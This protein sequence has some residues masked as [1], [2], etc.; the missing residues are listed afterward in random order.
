MEKNQPKKPAGQKKPSPTPSSNRPK[1]SVPRTSGR[2]AAKKVGK[3][4]AAVS[5]TLSKYLGKIVTYGLN[6][7]LTLLLIG[8]I[9]GSAMACAMVVYIKN[10]VDPV[11]DIENLMGD[12][13][14]T[15]FVYYEDKQADGTS[16][17]VEW[18]EERIH[19]T[20][21][22]MWVSYE[23]MP[24]DLINAFV[25]IEDKR[26]FTHKGV[27]I[28]R[29]TGAVLKFASGNHS[30][31]GSTITQ[32]LIKN[33]TGDD[34]VDIK[35]KIQE[36][37][38]ALNLESKRSKE[39]ILEMYLNTIYLSKG[40]YGVSAAAYEYFGKEVSE[41][42]LVECASLA[43]IP[44]N[45]TR[46]DPI[47]NPKENEKRRNTV[48]NEMYYNT[49]IAKTYTIDEIRS[50]K[51]ENL[52]LVRGTEEQTTSTVHSWFVDTLIF[53]II[54][55]L[56][57]TYNYDE[58]TA[59]QLLYSGGLQIYS[60]IDRNMQA[61]VDAIYQNDA[62]FPSHGTGVQVESAMTI[63]EQSTGN[64]VAIIG[65]R[66]VKDTP[67]GFNRATMAK[68]QPGSSIKPLSA[69][70]IALEKGLINYSTVFDDT[71]FKEDPTVWPNNWNFVFDGLVTVTN[72]VRNSKNTTAVKVVDML[73]VQTS[74]DFLVN[75][76]R[77]S[78]LEPSDMD[79]AP[80]A[81]G[82][83]TQGV[84]TRDMTAAYAA[85]ANNGIYNESKTYSKVLDSSGN[86]LLDNTNATTEVILSEDTCAVMTKLLQEVVTSGTGT[87]VTLRRKVDVAGK[88]GTTN[89]NNDLYFC[90]YTPYYTA[91]CW[92]GYDTPKGLYGFTSG[93][94][95]VAAA[96]YIWDQVM[97]AAHEDIIN[98]GNTRHFSEYLTNNLVTRSFCQDSGL[99]PG[100]HCHN[101]YRGSRIATGFYTRSNLPTGACQ[102]HVPVTYCA[103]TNCV[104]NPNCT[105][106]KVVSLIKVERAFKNNIR[107]TDAQY[108]YRDVP[109]GTGY[110]DNT[111]V[112]FY[113]H[114]IP[115]GTYVGYS[116][117]Q[118][119]ANAYC[120]VHKEAPKPPQEEPKDPEAPPTNPPTPSTGDTT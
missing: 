108:T 14:L 29:T 99:L 18:E 91:S 114:T 97:S 53:D 75:K 67:L 71:P 41:L 74:Y 96:T 59:K 8:I 38:R 27:D 89:N 104:A 46:Y 48:L 88:T 3:A 101:D 22:R 79:Y 19:G 47:S 21:N 15:T 92:V 87:A 49:D 116:E 83:F 40:C 109:T 32:Q 98:A 58:Q 44:K 4:S 93:Q 55:D 39:E 50:A 113:I 5:L 64:I 33:V 95:T 52:V 1:K 57:E 13:S 11:Y 76:Y 66:G 120:N 100:E 107:I 45:P 60:T 12:S 68:R 72:A 110:P 23:E 81:L 42:T 26:F 90:G 85:I 61:K 10:Y 28:K 2:T 63:I 78:T 80:L 6:A 25:S 30:Y 7:I 20:E 86:I 111:N 34:D 117:T 36:I 105:N 31:G 112:P 118:K 103:D 115:Q 82:G 65:G 84:T 24:E 35:R 94:R 73:G 62:L 102:T 69:Y 9:T 37:L 56:M 16:Q 119:Y 77:L 51:K 106:T 43:A 54:R 70:S 17:W